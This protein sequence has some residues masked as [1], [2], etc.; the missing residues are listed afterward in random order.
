MVSLI[1]EYFTL[2]PITTDAETFYK[3]CG[4]FFMVVTLAGLTVD[5]D[6]VRNQILSGP[7]V[8]TYDMVVTCILDVIQ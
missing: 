6:A 5:L 2:M 8:P 3:Q 7:T 1:V 4:Q